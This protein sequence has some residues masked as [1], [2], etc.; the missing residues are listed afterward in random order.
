MYDVCVYIPL[1]NVCKRLE[2]QDVG[3]NVNKIVLKVQQ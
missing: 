1:S 2:G 3:L